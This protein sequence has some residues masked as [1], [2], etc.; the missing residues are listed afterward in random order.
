MKAESDNSKKSGKWLNK[1]VVAMGFTSLFGDAGHEMVT[2]VLPFFLAA[3]GAGPEALGLIEGFSD[4]AS[5]F[6]KSFSGYLS[7]RIGKR[8]PIISVGYAL[9][10]FIKS[11]DRSS[12]VNVRNLLKACFSS[13]CTLQV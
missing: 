8:K 6:V 3:L 4:G 1:N 11:A 10:G 5:S 2:A 12:H 7:D 9:T 13:F